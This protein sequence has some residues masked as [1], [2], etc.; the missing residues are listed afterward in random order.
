MALV[1][2]SPSPSYLI[3]I[4]N[5]ARQCCQEHGMQ[6]VIHPCD[7]RNP[8]LP[9]ELVQLASHL[10]LE[11]LVL[12]P[13]VSVNDAV[14][15]ALE[16]ARVPVSLLAPVHADRGTCAVQLE[17]EQAAKQLLEHI[18]SLGHRRIGFVRGHPAFES[19][20]ARLAGFRPCD[21]TRRPRCA[22]GLGDRGRF[23]F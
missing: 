8:K 18:I 20:R 1:H 17:D 9:M 21:A 23:L 6:L 2:D 5:G 15:A 19:S 12:A 11:G 14:I 10:R 7:H 16:K 3:R 22:G 4:Q 13:P